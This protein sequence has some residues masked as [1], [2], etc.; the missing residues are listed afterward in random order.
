MGQHPIGSGWV[1]DHCWFVRKG[2]MVGQHPIGGGWGAGG[3]LHISMHL[4]LGGAQQWLCQGRILDSR[5]TRGF[6]VAECP[7]CWFCY[8]AVCLLCRRPL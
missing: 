4:L 5:I 8:R 1:A 3:G 6:A 2:D 7:C